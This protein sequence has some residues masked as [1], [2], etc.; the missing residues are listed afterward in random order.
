[1]SGLW[2]KVAVCLV[3]SPDD[4]LDA[5]MRCPCCEASDSRC[6]ERG[7]CDQSVNA[8]R[9]RHVRWLSCGGDGCGS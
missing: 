9:L 2:Q 7:A 1:M 3:E 6:A 8:V 4:A 5:P